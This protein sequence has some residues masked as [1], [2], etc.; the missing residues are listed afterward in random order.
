VTGIHATTGG[1]WKLKR[2]WGLRETAFYWRA[3]QWPPHTTRASIRRCSRAD[4]LFAAT[5][6]LRWVRAWVVL[7]HHW[8]ICLR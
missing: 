6:K 5:L 2:G 8:T 1:A 7:E 3:L 4:T